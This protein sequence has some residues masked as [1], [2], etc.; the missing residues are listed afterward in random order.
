MSTACVAGTSSGNTAIIQN[1][2]RIHESEIL[3]EQE[4]VF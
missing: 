3:L 4:L 2:L 1:I